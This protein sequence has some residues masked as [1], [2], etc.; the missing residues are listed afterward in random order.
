MAKSANLPADS[1]KAELVE[2]VTKLFGT[3]A[4]QITRDDVS[5][6][7]VSDFLSDNL[8][9]QEEQ[10]RIYEEQS[11]AAE[12]AANEAEEIMLEDGR[13][14]AERFQKAQT[15]A[16][17]VW[18]VA[19]DDIQYSVST[20][21]IRPE[22]QGKARNGPIPYAKYR[23]SVTIDAGRAVSNWS[24][25]FTIS[26]EFTLSAKAIKQL[27]KRDECHRAAQEAHDKLKQLKVEEASGPQRLRTIVNGAVA[28]CRIEAADG[29]TELI[30]MVMDQAQK[31]PV[32]ALTY[33]GGNQ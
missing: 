21:V 15:A 20:H 8:M 27:Q 25:Q 33:G 7:F 19:R 6:I 4:L 24:G 9:R 14:R 31:S 12:D 16:L 26:K 1:S 32:L 11:K 13:K 2:G 10:R 17:R 30:D 23:A 18:E 29:G 5:D 3:E 28:R 22:V